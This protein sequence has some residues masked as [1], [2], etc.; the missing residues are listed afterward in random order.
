MQ[1]LNLG[2]G[3]DYPGMLPAMFDGWDEVRVDMDP[4]TEPDI[5]ASL[6]D[7]SAI[8]TG[9]ADAVYS[10]HTLEH[11][12]AHDVPR[13]LDEMVRV[14]K[15][16]GIALLTMPDLQGVAEWLLDGITDAIVYES[17]GGPIAPLDIV[18][19]HRPSVQA[20]GDYMAHKT[21][22]TGDS[23]RR[24]LERAGFARIGINRDPDHLAL[25]ALAYTEGG[26]E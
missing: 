25:W 16:G 24:H 8:A 23:L 12:Y 11:L 21:G 19:G 20:C 22:F 4:A 10:S 14:L 7:L 13:A 3:P 15:P 9:S 17:P 5:V 6:T 26:G 2:S 1:V 18:Y